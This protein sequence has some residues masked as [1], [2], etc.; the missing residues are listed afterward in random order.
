MPCLRACLRFRL[1]AALVLLLTQA[2]SAATTATVIRF[3]TTTTTDNSG[4]IGILVPA[5][6]A[7]S[8]FTVHTIAGGSGRA[9]SLLAQGD[10]DIAL[11]HAPQREA[12]LVRQ[13]LAL[14]HASVMYNDFVL[15]GPARDPARAGKVLEVTAAFAAIAHGGHLFVSRADDSGTHDRE[16]ALW[17]ASGVSA[18]GDWYREAGQSMGKTL[19]IANELDA[20]TLVDRGTW[21][22][23]SDRL[24]LQVIFQGSDRLFNRYSV[25]SANPAL[26]P[27]VNTGGAAAL[28]AWLRS[29]QA[30]Q[31]I[32]QFV[33]RGQQLFVPLL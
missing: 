6:E 28:S 2:A 29:P 24:E 25:I 17:R 1:L 8:N 20:Y 18:R 10:V 5:F 23:F 11:T 21:L 9:L 27:D 32:R 19:E 31:L 22:A 16:L 26:H 12:E 14:N 13:G 30:K 4:L 7:D 3:A 33:I 15:V